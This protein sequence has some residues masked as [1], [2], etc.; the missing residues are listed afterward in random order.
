LNG[1]TA[2][3]PPD[4]PA[5]SSASIRASWFIATNCCVPPCPNAV[6]VD[7]SVSPP[8]STTPFADATPEDTAIPTGCPPTSDDVRYA[9]T[10]VPTGHG[11]SST[12]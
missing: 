12:R 6:Y 5:A 1:V 10:V 9:A 3:P 4:E 7:P 8:S 11:P 2:P